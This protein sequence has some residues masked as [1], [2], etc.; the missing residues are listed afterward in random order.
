MCYKLVW[1]HQ[2]CRLV[3]RLVS[4][5]VFVF[6]FSALISRLSVRPLSVLSAFYCKPN[7]DEARCCLAVIANKAKLLWNQWNLYCVACSFNLRR[8]SRR[9]RWPTPYLA[10][11]R[12]TE[13]IR[14]SCGIRRLRETSFWSSCHLALTYDAIKAY[15]SC[16][17]RRHI[18]G[19]GIHKILIIQQMLPS[20]SEHCWHSNIMWLFGQNRLYRVQHQLWDYV[21]LT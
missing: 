4:T 5:S 12:V 15:Q 10:G 6:A 20:L 13:K 18:G 2:L 3:F 19:S 9:Q 8:I 7:T 21:L 1:Q 16:R 14:K 11:E 17:R